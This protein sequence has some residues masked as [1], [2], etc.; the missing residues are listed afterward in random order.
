MDRGKVRCRGESEIGR[1][2]GRK[3]GWK[4]RGYRHGELLLYTSHALVLLTRSS[5]QRDHI[6]GSH[7][8]NSEY[9]TRS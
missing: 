1:E 8:L 4:W 5:S 9:Y 2:E 3:V 7:C 6:F